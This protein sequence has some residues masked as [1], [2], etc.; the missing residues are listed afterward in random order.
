[1]S[2]S[3][4]PAVSYTVTIIEL[5]YSGVRGAP[6]VWAT[7][8]GKG[9]KQRAIDCAEREFPTRASIISVTVHQ[10]GG[11]HDGEIVWQK[12]NPDAYMQGGIP[13][14]AGI[15]VK[16]GGEIMAVHAVS[17]DTRTADMRKPPTYTEEVL[18]GAWQVRTYHDGRELTFEQFIAQTEFTRT[19]LAG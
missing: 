18:Q 19:K 17:R 15:Y 11:A 3:T 14:C 7:C 10:V 6:L 1:M 9:A 4:K 8:T 2:K 13:Y 5:A 16:A 12:R